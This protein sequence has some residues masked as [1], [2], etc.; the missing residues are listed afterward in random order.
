M[1]FLAAWQGALVLAAVPLLH[2]LALG[3]TFAV[4]GRIS[5]LVDRVRHGA[6]DESAAE[7]SPEELLAAI[8]AETSATFGEDAVET[9]PPAAPSELAL[10]RAPDRESTHLLFFAGVVLGG[11]VS[12]LLNHS[13][14]I[15]PLLRGELFH[16]LLA[17][18][19]GAGTLALFAGGMLTGFG[20]RMAGGCTSGHGLCGVSQLQKGSLL[21]TCAFF[22]MGVAAS[23]AIGALS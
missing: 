22:G 23:F 6:R 19:P 5:A 14:A 15:T 12:S 13:F 11:V 7:M 4:S 16:S 17:K 2:W 10:P 18:T 8:R 21:A 3:R 9:T 20:T 1:H